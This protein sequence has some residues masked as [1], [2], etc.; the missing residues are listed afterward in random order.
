MLTIIARDAH[1]GKGEQ[2]RTLA[3]SAPVCL[4][5][6]LLARPVPGVNKN[7][8]TPKIE[9][10]RARQSLHATGTTHSQ[11]VLL[12]SFVSRFSCPNSINNN[13]SPS[14]SRSNWAETA[15]V[16]MAAAGIGT[17]VALHFLE[18]KYERQDRYGK[19]QLNNNNTSIE[20]RQYPY[21]A[22][23]LQNKHSHS[24]TEDELAFQ[25]SSSTSDDANRALG[26][27]AKHI[28]PLEVLQSLQKGNFRFWTGQA[29]RPE[30]SAFERR[31]LIKQQYPTT[32][33]LGCADSRVPVELVFD[34]G[35][36]DMFV[37]RVAGNCLGDTTKASLDYA[38][39]HVH[40][41]VLIVL[42]HEGCGAIKAAGLPSASIAR[43][44]LALRTVLTKLK[45]GLAAAD[46]PTNI[47]DVR[48]RDRE[49][50]TANVRNQIKA[51]VD[52]PEML[53]LINEGKLII[54]GGFYEIS[55]GIVDFFMQ[56]AKKEGENDVKPSP[57]VQSRYQPETREIVDA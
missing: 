24:P 57:G 27:Q 40:V 25:G 38:V 39:H 28:K 35:L 8:T 26:E 23:F 52:D 30:A 7:T 4:P 6:C 11:Q 29:K 20:G 36:G 19:D 46:L 10:K 49:A 2:N 37:V 16:A 13:M 42:G 3:I 18:K 34:Q 53:A 12:V 5:A 55:S 21:P 9:Q 45:E 33:V 32:V 56:V 43:E 50:G 22:T 44:P 48:A 54:V 17:Y 15:L 41:P 14:R 47:T 31:A 1:A 51:L